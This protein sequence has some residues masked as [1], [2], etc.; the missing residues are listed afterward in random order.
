VKQ[1]GISSGTLTI[2]TV[3]VSSL[4]SRDIHAVKTQTIPVIMDHCTNLL[5]VVT[6]KLR[7][8]GGTGTCGNVALPMYE[9]S[10]INYVLVTFLM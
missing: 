1:E 3:Q 5:D 10:A 9:T 6:F 7:F 8:A 4:G 2:V